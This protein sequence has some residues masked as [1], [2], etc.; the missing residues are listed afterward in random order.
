TWP[1]DYKLFAIEMAWLDYLYT[2]D[3]DY[4]RLVTLTCSTS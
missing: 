1:E 4:C 2:G 3:D